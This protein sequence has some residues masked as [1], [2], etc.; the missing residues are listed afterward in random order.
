MTAHTAS[1]TLRDDPLIDPADALAAARDHIV[2]AALTPSAGGRVGLEL[3]CHLIDLRRPGRRPEWDEVVAVAGSLPAMPSGSRVTLEP[4]GQIELSTPPTD[5]V[6]SSVAALRADRQVLRDGL[7]RAGFGAAPLGTDPARPVRRVNP[8]G[9]YVAME[10]HFAAVDCADPGRAMMTGTAALQVNLDAGPEAEWAQRLSLVAALGPVLV[11]A[12]AGSPYLAG[13]SSGW[14][15]MRQQIWHGIDH[16][17]SDPITPGSEPAQ[18]W[19]SYAL[20]APVMLVRPADGGDDV[21]PVRQRV[22][23]RDWLQ[24][25]APIERRPTLAD[26]DY[27]LTTLFPP[28]RPRG[29]VEIRCL[30]ALPDRWWPALATLT[31]VL[32]D[33][34]DAA[35]AAAE[36]TRPV[37]GAWEAAARDGL[38][39]PAIAAAVRGCVDVALVHCPDELRP[40]LTALADLVAAG[41][42]PS[43]ELRERADRVGPLRLLEEEAHA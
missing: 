27:H 33:D 2:A 29:Y 42:T 16:G 22:P 25:R 15:S 40:E 11:A 4:G 32:L 3:E 31:A 41:R 19:A 17:R 10:Q 37:V 6:A 5:D 20:D 43:D 38:R 24:G 23:F 7:A 14:H 9:R 36:L 35:A 18:A 28:V 13:E 1:S 30:D 12:S 21:H 34:P 8:S 39:D 26:L